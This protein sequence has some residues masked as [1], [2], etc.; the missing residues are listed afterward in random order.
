MPVTHGVTGSS[1]VRTAKSG[2]QTASFFCAYMSLTRNPSG[3]GYSAKP[4]QATQ[5]ES[6][7]HRKIRK[8]IGFLFMCA[9]HKKKERVEK[10]CFQPVH[11]KI[12]MVASRNLNTHYSAKL[13]VL[14]TVLRPGQVAVTTMLSAWVPARRMANMPP[15]K[16]VRWSV[17]FSSSE[18]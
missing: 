16:R 14:R 18:L 4:H 2:S 9:L 11:K 8:P 17:T 5:V 3:Q 10:E 6:R 13:N 1:P 15:L 7:T 12:K